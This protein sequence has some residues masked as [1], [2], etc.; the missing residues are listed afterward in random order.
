MATDLL[1]DL[2]TLAADLRA[3]DDRIQVEIVALWPAAGCD[4]CQLVE[5][6]GTAQVSWWHG[7]TECGVT[8]AA[9]HLLGWIDGFVIPDSDDEHI[10]IELGRAA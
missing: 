9:G 3:L 10:R 2:D 5:C 8:V 7:Q 6:D 1:L 4:L